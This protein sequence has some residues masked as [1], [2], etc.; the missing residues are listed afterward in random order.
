MT[1]HELYKQAIEKWSDNQLDMLVEECAELIKAVQ[2]LKRAGDHGTDV[3]LA[4]AMDN[5][6]EEQEDVEIMLCQ[7]RARNPK[8]GQR[9]RIKHMKLT[10]LAGMLGETYKPEAEYA[11]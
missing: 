7:M 9:A 1:E 6:I 4:A 3:E 10:R 2:K 11:E 8:K 5:F